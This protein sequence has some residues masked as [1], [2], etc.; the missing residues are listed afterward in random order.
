MNS[1]T[2]HIRPANNNWFLINQNPSKWKSFHIQKLRLVTVFLWRKVY[3]DNGC[4][5]WKY[6]ELVFPN[7]CNDIWRLRFRLVKP[8]WQNL[9]WLHRYIGREE[10]CEKMRYY[11]CELVK[12]KPLKDEKGNL[13]IINYRLW[14][15][16]IRL[17]KT[18]NTFCRKL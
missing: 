6:V 11:F 9:K 1:W 12:S 18:R 7:D 14:F 10:I 16:K 2:V 13:E 3:D 15:K 8:K 4:F 17:E 5:P